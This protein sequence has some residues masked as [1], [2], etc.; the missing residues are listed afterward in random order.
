MG[1]YLYI[2]WYFSS[3]IVVRDLKGYLVKYILKHFCAKMIYEIQ[4]YMLRI[5]TC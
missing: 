5:Q 4:Q 2:Y 3:E 1:E